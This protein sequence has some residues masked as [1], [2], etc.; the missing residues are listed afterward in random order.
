[1]L[2]HLL[3]ERTRLLDK[4][5]WR[6]ITPQGERRSSPKATNAIGWNQLQ[7]KGLPS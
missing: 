3:S 1:M 5:M 2:L 7:D 4:T 6:F